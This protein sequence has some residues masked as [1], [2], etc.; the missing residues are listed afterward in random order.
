MAYVTAAEVRAMG[1]AAPAIAEFTDSEVLAHAA[2]IEDEADGFL[3][4]R[5]TTPLNETLIPLALKRHL[6]RATFFSLIASRG[7]SPDGGDQMIV[8]GY[9]DFK[10]YLKAISQGLISI[11][12]PGGV[13]AT[14][15]HIDGPRV[16][17]EELRTES[18]W[19]TD[20]WDDF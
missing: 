17:S 19:G 3:R 2:A 7:F 12:I 18:R 16:Y 14:A 1:G 9:A 4:S 5:Y 13:A 11:E 10:S 15:T 6:A 20:S 8:D